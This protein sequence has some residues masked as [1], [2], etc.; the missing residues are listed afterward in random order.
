MIKDMEVYPAFTVINR[1]TGDAIEASLGK[2]NPEK[3]MSA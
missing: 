1:A 3:K 2:G